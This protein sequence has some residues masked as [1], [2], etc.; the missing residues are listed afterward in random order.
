MEKLYGRAISYFMKVKA[1]SDSEWLQEIA[2]LNI[3]RVHYE[4]R[5]YRQS[6]RYYAEIPRESDNWLQALF[7]GSWAFFFDEKIQSHFG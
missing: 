3:A 4:A 5:R 6:L 1:N 7:E 2:N